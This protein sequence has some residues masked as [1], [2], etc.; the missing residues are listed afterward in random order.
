MALVASSLD[1]WKEIWTPASKR[2]RNQRTPVIGARSN[3]AF[4]VV[5]SQGLIVFEYAKQCIGEK[6][7]SH[8]LQSG[9][10]IHL[11]LPRICW[12]TCTMHCFHL[13]CT[14]AL[15]KSLSK[16]LFIYIEA[17]QHGA[18]TRQGML[19]DKGET[20]KRSKGGSQN[21]TLCPELGQLLYDWFID[22]VQIYRSRVNYALIYAHARYFA[23]YEYQ[24]VSLK[25]QKY[26]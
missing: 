4:G 25:N 17:L 13:R 21:R 5:L 22:C 3:K 24:L 2:E 6:A 18:T 11:R 15:R 14:D 16:A 8:I 12:S 19:A 23:S 26:R 10:K 20:Q 1:P 9:P 7:M